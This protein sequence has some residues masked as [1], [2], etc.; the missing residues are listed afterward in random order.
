M[1]R[2][3]GSS[4]GRSPTCRAS[5]PRSRSPISTPPSGRIDLFKIDYTPT[6][7]DGERTTDDGGEEKVLFVLSVVW[8]V[9]RCL[10]DPMRLSISTWNINSVRLRIE[11]AGEIHQ[12]GPPGRA[13]PAGD[14]VPG[15]QISAQ[16]IQAARLRARRPQRTEG[17]SRRGGAFAPA[18][19][20][21][22]VQDSAARRIAAMSRPCWASARAC[23]SP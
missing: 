20:S 10:M 8:S 3:T 23:A 13:V 1:P 14:Q 12:G 11:L 16:A 6:S 9:L 2:T 4:S 5:T 21:F 17:L 7:V 15:R 18:V 19:R 22:H